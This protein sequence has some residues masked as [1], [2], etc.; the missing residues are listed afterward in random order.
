[1]AGS[2]GV[3]L[4]G[5]GA[6]GAY[7]VGV[8]KALAGGQSPSTGH[9]PLDPAVIAATSIGSFNA[10]VLLSNLTDSLGSAV[11]ALQKVWL[12]RISL[13][14]R[15]SRNGVFRVRANP[16][17]W[18]D[19]GVIRN[20]PLKPARDLASDAMFLAKDWSARAR[21][22]TTS[23]GSL[24]RRAAE[25][26]DLSTFVTPAPSEE[27][28]RETVS[29]PRVRS[30]PVAL[31][32]TAT[33]WRNGTLRLFSNADFTDAI[34]ASILL[35]S[36]AIPGIF[37]P[38]SID[39]EPFADG[40]VVLN[41]PLKP[42]IDAGARTLHV[43]YLDPDPAAIPLKPVGSTID[44]IGRMFAISFAATMKRD[45]E[46]ASRINQGIHAVE[47]AARGESVRA[48]EPLHMGGRGHRPL[49]IHLYHPASDWGGTLGM[50]DFQRDRV[51]RL[52]ERGYNDAV[53]HDCATAG[54]VSG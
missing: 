17:S 19:V 38:V 26:V 40:G 52:I 49:Q 34:G 7:E 15:A 24:E 31:K 32:V 5:G 35:A 22:F 14:G 48:L 23:S 51:A 37:P 33:R 41:T 18:I 20:D 6:N 12:E 10:A 28:V 44:T 27:L 4:S 53:G 21:E 25:L 30:A 16:L 8:L 45:L 9:Q 36:G 42:A 39:G 13:S 46:I 2:T 47:A 54:C 50:L 3:V 43:I 1:M 11:G 29:L